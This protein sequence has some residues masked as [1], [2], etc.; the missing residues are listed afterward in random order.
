MR[1]HVD[2]RHERVL[3]IVRLRGSLRVTELADELGVSTVTVRRDV[4]TLAEKGRL[5]RMHG[6]VVWPEQPAAGEPGG[7]SAERA[8]RDG[9]GPVLGMVI[10]TVAHY[11]TDIVR[12]ARKAVAEQGGRLVLGLSQYLAEEDEAQA[13]RLLASGADGLL[14]APSWGWGAPEPGREEWLLRREVPTV[15]MERWVPPVSP[16]A[17]LDRVRSD[18]AHGMAIA[19]RHLASLGHGK[20]AM[21]APE[22]PHAPQLRGGYAAAV[23]ALGLTPVSPWRGGETSESE[24]YD[25]TLDYLCA[26]HAEGVR[27][28]IVHNDSDA[29]VLVPRLHARGIKVP[30]DMAIVAYD[31]LVA[32][33]SEIPL[34]A[35]A[36]PKAAVGEF[37]ARLLLTRIAER[38]SG[39]A[40]A[41]LP[42]QHV[43]LLP[44]LRVRASCGSA[45]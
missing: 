43:D 7:R 36:P 8:P 17:E 1:L 29:V 9:D 42:R 15:L 33:L 20:V 10:P 13:D 45:G 2:Q 41:R 4:E 35:V 14:L 11:F 34:T 16:A 32:G 19:V 22:S 30:E 44:H 28:A 24:R 31:D 39:D 26:L 40:G 18:S 3:E 25:T 21:I 27:A 38:S 23:E 12:G 6:A 5:R 37:A